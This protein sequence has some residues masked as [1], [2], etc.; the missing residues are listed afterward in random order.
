MDADWCFCA[1]TLWVRSAFRFCLPV[2]SQRKT[3]PGV[4]EPA[5]DDQWL[6]EGDVVARERERVEPIGDQVHAGDQEHE[7]PPA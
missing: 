4:P 7:S 6:S 2:G 5:G 1:S 3:G